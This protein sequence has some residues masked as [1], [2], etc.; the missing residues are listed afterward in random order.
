MTA[1]I[2]SSEPKETQIIITVSHGN[3]MLDF[4]DNLQNSLNQA[5]TLAVKSQLTYMDTDGSPIKVGGLVMT[6]KSKKEPKV[7]ESPWGAVNVPRYVYQSSQGGE[8]FC[9]LDQNARIIV[10]STPAFAR[11]VSWKYAHMAAPKVEKDLRQNHGRNSSRSTLRDVADVV[12]SIAQAKVEKWA[13]DIPELPKPVK[14]VA[15]GLDGANLLYYEGYRIAMCG[16][17]SLYDDEGERLH[18]LYC[19]AAP[20]YG[21]QTFMTRFTAEIEKI[22]KRFPDAV[23]VG[24]AD[25]APDN[26]TFLEPLTSVQVLDFYHVSEYVADAAEALFPGKKAMK[27][28][29]AWLSQKL[30]DLKHKKGEG[31][32]LRSELDLASPGNNRTASLEK[33]IKA[34]TYFKN[35]WHQMIY[36]EARTKNLSIGSG[37]TEAACK[38]LVKERMCKSGMR[39]KEQGAS[40]LL[41]LRALVC[42]TGHWDAFWSKMNRYGFPVARNLVLVH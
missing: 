16:T 14:A 24:V 30:H 41:T 9:P 11:M 35:H 4:E 22:K 33:L 12:A 32:N 21:K 42:S 8:T 7:Y 15:I 19:A 5:G 17:I 6:C 18:T 40:M 36:P 27:E 25:G 13:Y 29:K 34:R 38:S 1:D 3:S 39:W 23:Y 10:N 26:W 31:L 20:E 37:V 28:R 2:L